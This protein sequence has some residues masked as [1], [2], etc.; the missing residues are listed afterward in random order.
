[1]LTFNFNN[2]FYKK[3]SLRTDWGHSYLFSSLDLDVQH[4]GVHSTKYSCM[5]ETFIQV[6]CGEFPIPNIRFKIQKKGGRKKK[7]RKVG[8]VG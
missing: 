7:G 2:L 1:M 3:L 5:T 6:I 4:C 8:I